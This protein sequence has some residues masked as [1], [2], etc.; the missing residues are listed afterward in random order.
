MITASTSL[1]LLGVK[2]VNRLANRCTLLAGADYPL[3]NACLST[4]AIALCARGNSW[5]IN[6]ID[7]G[8][9]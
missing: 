4:P 1:Y 5:N 2:R 8:I 6:G 9:Y 3:L 7:V